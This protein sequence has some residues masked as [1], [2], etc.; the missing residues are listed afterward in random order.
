MLP[1]EQPDAL[2]SRPEDLPESFK[3]ILKRHRKSTLGE[4]VSIRH[5]LL[6]R[7]DRQ[8]VLLRKPEPFGLGSRDPCADVSLDDGQKGLGKSKLL[9]DLHAFKGV[10]YIVGPCPADVMKKPAQ[11]NQLAVNAYSFHLHG[12]SDR[13]AGNCRAVRD[14]TGGTPGLYQN[15]FIRH[16]RGIIPHQDRSINQKSIWDADKIGLTRMKKL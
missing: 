8:V 13:G 16:R 3:C 9:P 2:M 15:L 6:L 11:P 14:H 10:S 4:V 12:K 7:C 5:D 1:D